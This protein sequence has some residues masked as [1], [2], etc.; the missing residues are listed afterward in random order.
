MTHHTVCILPNFKPGAPGGVAMHI[1]ML[2]KHLPSFGWDIVD[3]PLQA[4]IVHTHAT[5]Q[6]AQTDVFSCHGIYPLKDDQPSWQRRANELIFDNLKLAHAVIAVSGWTA[7]QWTHLTGVK[8]VIIGNGVDLDDWHNV[9]RGVWRKRLSIKDETPIVLWGKT[10][11]SD[12]LD[13]TP[14]LEIA[15][16]RPDVAVVIPVAKS[17]LPNAPKN[18]FCVG[19]LPFPD[20]KVLLADCDVYLATVQEN[21]SIQVLEAM[22]LEKPVLGFSWGG[23]AETITHDHDG[24]LVTPYDYPALLEG[25]DIAMAQSKRLGKN[26]RKT[27]EALYQ[28]TDQVAQVAAVYEAVLEEKQAEIEAPKCSIVI[29]N[30]NKAAYIREAIESSL[31][32]QS[33]PKYEVIVVDDGSTDDSL[34]IIAEYGDDI[35]VVSQ[36]NAGVANARNTGIYMASGEYICC[37]DGDDRLNPYFLNR[38]SAALDADP[39][40]GIAYSD[41]LVFGHDDRGNAINPATVRCDEYDFERLV[42]RNFLPCANLFRKRAWERANGYKSVIDQYGPSWEDY[43]LWLHM[44]KLGWY[45]RRVPGPLFEYR[46]VAKT[47]RA[48]DSRDR[49][50]LLRAIVNRLHRDL[51]P[52][53]VS[54]V[55]P[56]YKQARFLTDS[57]QS[58]LDQTFPDFEIVVVD[59]GNESEEAAVIAGIVAEYKRQYPDTLRLE[60]LAQN[61]GLAQARNHGVQTARGRWIVPLDADDKLMPT[62]LEACLSAT[63]LNAQQFAYTDAVLWWEKTGEE[64]RLEAHEYDFDETLKRLTFACSIMYAKEAWAGVG[65]YKPQMSEVGGWE[66][67]EFI[68]SLGEIGVC[69]VRVPE[70]LFFYRQHSENQMRHQAT[71]NKAIL[72]E[73]MRR[74][75]AATY[76]GEKPMGCCGGKRPQPKNLPQAMTKTVV[77]DANMIMVRYVGP[78]VG[79]QSWRGPSGRTYQFGLSDPLQ[80]CLPIDADFFALRADFVKVT[81]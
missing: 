20:M 74:L 77:A 73:T 37:L 21:H 14:A 1:A 53:L 79:T 22:A 39:G 59:D 26:A 23:T 38:L 24:W 43:E 25:L 10:S 58:V 67:W 54:V 65:G 7:Q 66:D 29:T 18:V 64:K 57:L 3:N 75:H 32:Q 4:D 16:R 5:E 9:K 2:K 17:L 30:Y 72:Q 50:H 70:P 12:V 69:G 80:N 45:G 68:I 42:Q 78:S 8:P 81:A 44:G 41:M 52:P 19:M 36:A 33:A 6:S 60:V 47:G 13:P 31:T 15:I 61:G 62:F 35:R 34:K 40:L 51:Y 48:Y 63:E 49:S 28:A 11:F 55:I 46:K 56:C 71:K 76:R 27:V